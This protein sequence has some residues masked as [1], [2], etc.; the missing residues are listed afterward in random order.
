MDMGLKKAYK[1][2]YKLKKICPYDNMF[3]NIKNKIK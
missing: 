3:L 1:K 2:S